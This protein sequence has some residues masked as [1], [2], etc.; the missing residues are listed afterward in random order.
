M[1]FM[2]ILL[3]FWLLLMTQIAATVR[4]AAQAGVPGQISAPF[5]AAAGLILTLGLTALPIVLQL[6]YAMAVHAGKPLSLGPNYTDDWLFGLGGALGLVV[7]SYL[8]I[9][10]GRRGIV[11]LFSVGR[12]TLGLLCSAYLILVVANHLVFFTLLP[13]KAGVMD[14]TWFNQAAGAHAHCTTSPLVVAGVGTGTVTYRCPK[15]GGIAFA[16]FSATPLVPWPGYTQG[17]SHKVAMAVEHLLRT[18]QRPG[19]LGSVPR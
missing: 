16:K 2:L 19:R 15:P 1:I 17:T 10:Q 5:L 7:Y 11:G 9:Q 8:L 6:T 14:P 3:V 4:M 13:G 18:A 12:P